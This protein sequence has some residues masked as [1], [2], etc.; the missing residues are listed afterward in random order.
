MR[1]LERLF[2]VAGGLLL[3]AG[4]GMLAAATVGQSTKGTPVARAAKARGL[5][6]S[7]PIPPVLSFIDVPG[8]AGAQME[9][10]RLGRSL[11]VYDSISTKQ[12]VLG[13]EWLPGSARLG[14]PGNAVVAAHRDTHFRFLKDLRVGDAIRLS[15]PSRPVQ[16]YEVRR[17]TVVDKNDTR[18][19]RPISGNVLTLVTCYPFYYLGHA[20]K[21]FIVTAHR[22]G[23]SPASGG[24]TTHIASGVSHVKEP[25]QEDAR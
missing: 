24:K 17:L 15:L 13:P 3:A 20:P 9:W 11:L 16:L 6:P 25:T 8:V 7:I 19:L 22:T 21:R 23:V 14:D 2:L 10:P 18:L 1:I 5:R 4:L 12:M